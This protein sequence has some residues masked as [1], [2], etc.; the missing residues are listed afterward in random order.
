MVTSNHLH[1][2]IQFA[3]LFLVSIHAKTKRE[4]KCLKIGRNCQ[5]PSFTYNQQILFD[6]KMT[7]SQNYSWKNEKRNETKS[8]QNVKE[9]FIS[10]LYRKYN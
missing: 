8:I 9:N 7:L 5:L 10:S 6:V 1:P 4:N 3:I 2:F